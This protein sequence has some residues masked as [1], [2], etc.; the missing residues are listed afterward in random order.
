MHGAVLEHSFQKTQS[1]PTTPSSLQT[2]GFN[3]QPILPFARVSFARV[4]KKKKSVRSQNHRTVR[5]HEAEVF[6]VITQAVVCIYNGYLKNISMYCIEYCI[7]LYRIVLYCD[8]FE[9]QEGSSKMLPSP[10]FNGE[11]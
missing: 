7:L 5:S 11:K 1:T 4:H 6:K 8:S 10:R 9:N 2:N 3:V